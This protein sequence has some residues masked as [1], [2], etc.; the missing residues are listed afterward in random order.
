[1]FKNIREVLLW[2]G[3]KFK[4]KKDLVREIENLWKIVDKLYTRVD[5][6]ETISIHHYDNRH[7]WDGHKLHD[8]VI[9]LLDHTGTRPK[10]R[11]P[12]VLEA[13]DDE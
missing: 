11:H 8:V 9:A 10:A 5:R 12:L 6:L 4:T 7:C 1:M 13:K 3:R 2:N